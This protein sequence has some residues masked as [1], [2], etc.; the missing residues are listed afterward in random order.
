MIAMQRLMP[1]P[2]VDPAQQRMMLMMPIIFSGMFAWAPAGLNLYWF[3]SNLVAMG[4][5]T[6]AMYFAP[7]LFPKAKGSS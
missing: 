7:H 4:Q 6:L 5:Q 3:V 2:A 1:A